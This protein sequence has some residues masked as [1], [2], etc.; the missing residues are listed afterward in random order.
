MKSEVVAY[1]LSLSQALT[2]GAC[3]ICGVLKEFQSALADKVQMAGEVK[4]CNFHTWL[5]ARGAP[6]ENVVA[7]YWKMLDRSSI[8]KVGPSECDFCRRTL[9]EEN[10]RLHELVQYMQRALFLEWMK[11]QA[12]LCLDHARKLDQR[13]PLKLRPV[14]REIV[15]RTRSELKQELGAFLEQA[16]RGDHAGGGVLGRAA[17][18]LVSQRGL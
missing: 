14:I 11:S 4:L 2:R 10:V 1:E 3:P 12:S 6:A 7:F 15:E 5:L 16:V 17:E 18:F 9:D 8:G 13:A